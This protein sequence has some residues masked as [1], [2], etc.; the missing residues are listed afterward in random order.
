MKIYSDKPDK[1][2]YSHIHDALQYVATGL[3]TLEDRR[4]EDAMLEKITYQPISSRVGW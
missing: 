3:F 1:N 2:K 4:Q